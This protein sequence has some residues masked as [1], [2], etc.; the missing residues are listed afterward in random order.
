M[1]LSVDSL[2]SLIKKQ[3]GEVLPDTHLPVFHIDD[4]LVEI[5]YWSPKHLMLLIPSIERFAFYKMSVNSHL[6]GGYYKFKN[7]K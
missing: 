5:Q 6:I 3:G 2:K 1:T 7:R 4:E